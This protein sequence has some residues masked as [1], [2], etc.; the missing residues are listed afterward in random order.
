MSNFD[1]SGIID[2]LPQLMTGLYYTLLI[3]IL[4]LI[5]GFALGALFGLGRVSQNKLVYGLA[6][7]YVE[8]VRGTP[9]LVQ[10]IWIFFALPLLI[11][12]N[13]DSVLAGVIVIRSEEHTSELQSRGHLVCRLLLEKK[14]V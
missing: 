5:I 11:G 10:A 7:I 12:V 2:F 6:T 8:I 9:V 13:L 14:N 3:S 4:G 1:W